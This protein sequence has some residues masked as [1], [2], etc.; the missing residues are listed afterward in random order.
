MPTTIPWHIAL[1]LCAACSALT[2]TTAYVRRKAMMLDT[3]R[4]LVQL[5]ERVFVNCAGAMTKKLD[6]QQIV[7]LQGRLRKGMLSF[8]DKEND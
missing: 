3:A 1:A 5:F 7:E 2:W 8:P 6:D 4:E